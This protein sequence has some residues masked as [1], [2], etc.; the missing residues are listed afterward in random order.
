MSVEFYCGVFGLFA[1][2]FLAW[3]M[4]PNKSRV[5][6][7]TVIFGLG[8]QLGLGLLV[9]LTQPGQLFF[10]Y[11]NDIIIGL[12][13]FSDEGARFLFGQLVDREFAQAN[14]AF[15]VLCTIIFFSSIMSILY[16]T[17]IMQKI[18]EFVAWLMMKILGTSG[19]ETLSVS[20]NIFVGQTE[21]PL[22]VKPFIK[23]MTQSELNTVMTGGFATVAGGVMAAYV[24]MLH[25]AFA[26]IAGHLMTASIM[27]APAAIVMSKLAFPEISKPKTGGDVEINVEDQN[28][29]VIEAAASGAKTGLTLALNVGAMLLAFIALVHLGNFIVGWAGDHIHSLITE[30]HGHSAFIWGFVLGLILMIFI[31]ARASWQKTKTKFWIGGV[32]LMSVLPVTGFYLSPYPTFSAVAGLLLGIVIILFWQKERRY[33]WG[34]SLGILI[35]GACVTGGITWMIGGSNSPAIAGAVTFGLIAL[36]CSLPLF[37]ARGSTESVLKIGLIVVFVSFVAGSVIS[38]FDISFLSVLGDF[39]LEKLFG[40]AFSFLAFLMGVPWEDLVNF[41]QLIGHKVVVNEFVA[42]ME[43]QKMAVNEAIRPR[44][45][46]IAS[47]ALT[48]FANF[49]SIAIQIGGIGGIAPNRESDLAKLGLRAMIAGALA[50]FQTAAVAGVM[51]AISDKMGIDL[52]NLGA[53]L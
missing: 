26:G 32:F 30:L 6:W 40:Y 43:L 21:A 12:L 36:L 35:I 1:L 29:N 8:L 49:S 9:M 46:V 3:L 16:Y 31:V 11:M 17:G 24:G 53:S 38:Y 15:S 50:S 51:F 52:V 44:S 48:G 20:S 18:V 13:K 39:T 41:G 37:W 25:E 7:K 33:K 14:F 23:D 34:N 22:V 45:L 42:F 4:S 47:Y 28:S 5:M 10:A 19:A 27:S 2:P